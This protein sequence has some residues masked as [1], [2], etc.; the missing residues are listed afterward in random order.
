M[1]YSVNITD[2]AE[3]DILAAVKYISDRLKNPKVANNLLDEIEQHEN[4]LEETPN[5]LPK[6]ELDIYDSVSYT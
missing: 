4:I 5:I 2:L 6:K 1:N 3:E